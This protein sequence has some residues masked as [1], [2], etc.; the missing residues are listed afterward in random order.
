MPTI[1]LGVLCLLM[2]IPGATHDALQ[3][4]DK[5]R[6]AGMK[7]PPVWPIVKVFGWVALLC[8]CAYLFVDGRKPAQHPVAASSPPVSQPATPSV[9]P[10]LPSIHSSPRIVQV[11]P[12]PLASPAATP[13]PITIG[14]DVDM[15]GDGCQQKIIGGSGNINNCG[16][17]RKKYPEM[18]AVQ[19]HELAS[20]LESF[21]PTPLGVVA[22]QNGSSS[23]TITFQNRLAGVLQHLYGEKSSTMFATLAGEVPR[24]VISNGPS[25][26][27]PFVE[28]MS[29]YLV[30]NK[31]ID[32]P[33]TY[34]V[35]TKE[36]A[37]LQ[38]IIG[39]PQ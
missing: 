36:G 15:S 22:I 12:K 19:Q 3:L 5:W 13:P 16:D 33:I 37:K 29:R 20:V 31:F 23:E 26:D 28:A 24:G 6:A 17:R 30:A 35:V 14:G 2:A 18:T 4:R 8:F 34:V 27:K 21:D 7:N 11:S 1:I 39:E 10:V 38:I 25:K 32:K 9:A